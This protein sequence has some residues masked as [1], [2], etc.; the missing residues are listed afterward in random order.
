[1]S[2]VFEPWQILVVLAGVLGFFA[3]VAW[4]I[5]RSLHGVQT[6]LAVVKNNTSGQYAEMQRQ[7]Q[8]IEALKE[9]YATVRSLDSRQQRLERQMDSLLKL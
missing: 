3:T 5:V 1:M 6:E 2:M 4:F 8:D 7:A 9:K